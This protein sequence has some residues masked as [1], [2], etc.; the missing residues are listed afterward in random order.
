M[1]VFGM[2]PL[3]VFFLGLVCSSEVLARNIGIYL[4][5]TCG[6]ATPIPD[7]TTSNRIIGHQMNWDAVNPKAPVSEGDVIVMCNGMYCVPYTMNSDRSYTGG[8]R[9]PQL[10]PAYPPGAG[11]GGGGGGHTPPGSGDL[12]GG[13][14]CGYVNGVL[15]HCQMV[16]QYV[17]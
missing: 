1:K 15:D 17:A 9:V 10:P 5:N 14:I 8:I 11:G 16:Y 4:C 13:L 6:V 12:V 7:S 3:A 2:V